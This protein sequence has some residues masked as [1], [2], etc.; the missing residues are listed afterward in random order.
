MTQSTAVSLHGF[1]VASPWTL[2]ARP[3]QHPAEVRC[4]VERSVAPQLPDS[5]SGSLV[6]QSVD[7]NGIATMQVRSTATGHLINW[8]GFM[9]ASLNIVPDGSVRTLHLM[10]HTTGA[11]RLASVLV[12]PAVG[13]VAMLSGALVLHATAVNIDGRAVLLVADRGGGKSSVAALLGSAGIPLLA[14]DVCAVSIGVDGIPVV[15][16][17]VQELR[18]RPTTPWLAVL[19]GLVRSE[20]HSDGRIVVRPP[21]TPRHCVPVGAVMVVRLSR[22]ADEVLVTRFTGVQAASVL[23]KAQRCPPTAGSPLTRS[24]FEGSAA[25]ADALPVSALTVPWA[26]R[27]RNRQLGVELRDALKAASV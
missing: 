21:T 4:T 25:C 24:A 26:E 19:P 17:G 23:I 20:R 13:V 8:P 5:A 27:R 16:A 18:L 6:A 3:S 1:V 14:E 9:S 15:H 11:L 12:S 22:S 7:E 10:A 2:S